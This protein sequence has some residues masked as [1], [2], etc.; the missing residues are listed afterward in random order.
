MASIVF[1]SKEPKLFQQ[2]W[3]RGLL[4]HQATVDSLDG[5]WICENG[6]LINELMNKIEILELR[7]SALDNKLHCVQKG[8]NEITLVKGNEEYWIRKF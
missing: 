4:S 6:L 3:E 5:M 7:F 1:K 2:L 8:S